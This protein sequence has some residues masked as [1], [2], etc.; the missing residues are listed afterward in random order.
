MQRL[1][2]NR[3]TAIIQHISQYWVRQ[4][5]PHFHVCKLKSATEGLPEPWCPDL[6]EVPYE[7]T[8]TWT[9]RITFA[10]SVNSRSTIGLHT[11]RSAAGATDHCRATDRCRVIKLGITTAICYQISPLLVRRCQTRR[12]VYGTDKLEWPFRAVRRVQQIPLHSE[13]L[14]L[15]PH[16]AKALSDDFVWRLSLYRVH[17]A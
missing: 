15:R 3:S 12:A 8:R 17:R 14:Y 10:N 9:V 13:L 4:A 6:S 5:N 7:A 16:R 11:C 2:R 1:Q